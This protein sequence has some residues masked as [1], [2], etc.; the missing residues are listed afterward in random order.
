MPQT[1]P[2][3]P[4]TRRL[5]RIALASVGI[6]AIWAVLML[7]GPVAELH[8]IAGLPL[9][10]ER[11]TGYSPREVQALLSGLGETGREIYLRRFL[12]YDLPFPLIYTAALWSVWT[13]FARRAGISAR[14]RHA[15]QLLMLVPLLLDLAENA[16]IAA[17]LISY[18]DAPMVP[19]GVTSLFTVAKWAGVLAALLAI[20]GL[21][22][23]LGRK[24]RQA[25]RAGPDGP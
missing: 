18:P 8:R 10:D 16:Q 9:L 1:R 13:W 11:V 12:A 23:H 25:L 15:G 21:S 6:T 4:A 2:E 17:L 24:G 7:T 22:A 14:V 3:A 19:L 20:A 5:G